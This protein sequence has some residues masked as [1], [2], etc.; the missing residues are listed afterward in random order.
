MLCKVQI[1]SENIQNIIEKTF[2]DPIT[3]LL[4]KNSNL[5]RIQF[6]TI[7]IDLLIDIISDV[8]VTYYQKTLFRKEKISRGSFSRSLQQAR[9]NIIKSIFTIVLLSYIGVFDE[10]PFDEYVFL[11]E[12]L[13]EYVIILQSNQFDEKKQVLTRIE[14]ELLNGIAELATPKSIKLM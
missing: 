13:K 9:R 8:N 10:K 5:T 4:L 3:D 11:A 6:E 1:V 7:V 12:K 14:H 2:K